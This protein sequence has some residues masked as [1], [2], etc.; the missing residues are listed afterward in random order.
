MVAN[1]SESSLAVGEEIV[2]HQPVPVRSSISASG[3]GRAR[4]AVAD[5]GLRRRVAS[6]FELRGYQ[7]TFGPINPAADEQLV[8]ILA[9]DEAY[10]IELANSLTNATARL[11]IPWIAL[12]RDSGSDAVN[13]AIE[14]GA[15]D[16]L[17][18][19]EEIDALD[20]RLAIIERRIERHPGSAT[21]PRRPERNGISQLLKSAERQAQELQ[22]L[23]RIRTAIAV[24]FA[25]PTLFRSI[26]EQVAV[27]FGY[28]HVSIYRLESGDLL[29]QH[30]VGYDDVLERIPLGRGVA[31]RVARTGEA[32]LIEDVGADPDFLAAI[33]GIRSEICVPFFH[34]GRVAG[35]FNVESTGERLLTRAD[36]RLI[37]EVTGFLGLAVERSQLMTAIQDSEQRLRL[38]LEAAGMGTWMWHPQTGEVVWSEQMGPLYGLPTGT[39][40]LSTEDWFQ[41]IHQ[42]DRGLV[43]RKD[44]QVMRFGDEYEI[45]FRV[46]LA[47]GAIR[48]LEGKGR[49]VE[50]DDAG[51][52]LSI[53]GVTMDVTGR[54]RLE[55]ERLRLVQVETERAKAKEAQRLITDTLE[56][57]SA[58]FIAVDR[59]WHPTFVNQRA[60]VMLGLNNEM[61]SGTFWEMLPWLEG[62]DVKYELQAAAESQ[63]SAI[64]DVAWPGN[65][66]WFEVHLY[67]AQDGLSISLQDV[68]ERR[69]AEE[70]QRRT[71]ER[72]RS[73]VQNAS[74]IILILD[75]H[76]TV[77]YASP[78]IER[79]I[80]QPAEEIV[81]GD[82]FSLVHPQDAKRLRRAFVKVAMTAG[83]SPP[84]VLRFRHKLG[85]YRWLEVTATNLF[86]DP[87]IEGIVANCRDVTERHDAEFNLWFLAETSSMVGTSLDLETTLNS[88]ARLIVMNLGE[89]CIVDVVNEQL[90]SEA[91]A[92]AHR[93]AAVERR[94]VQYRSAWPLNRA[95]PYGP[96]YV[97]KTGRSLLYGTI[98]DEIGQLWLS[99]SDERS[100]PVNFGFRSAIVVPLMARGVTTGVLTVASST[101]GRFSGVDLGL[102]EELARRAAM[103]VDNARLYRAARSAVEARD[104]FLSVA[105]HEL[106]T[107]ITAI[108]GFTALLDRE[109]VHRNDPDR[110]QRFVRRLTDAGARLSLLVDDMLDV[111]RIRLGQLPLRIA[112]VDLAA[113]IE[114]VKQRYEEQETSSPQRFVLDLSNRECV[115]RA[116]DDRLDQVLSNVVDNAKKYSAE[117]GDIV[118]SLVG[119]DDGCLLRV[120]DCGIGL[121]VDEL[122][123]IFRPFGR[124]ANAVSSNVSGLGIGLFISRNIIERHGGRIWA[125]SEGEGLGTTIAIWLPAGGISADD[126]PPMV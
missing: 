86:D 108:T 61:L 10:L 50:R 114:R 60:L 72:F 40:L 112:D 124:A 54:K 73:L 59:D 13:L 109:V 39:T 115:I 80:G 7:L 23:H 90:E 24:D 77:R 11:A 19:P 44:R 12:V 113:L 120:K 26:V 29:L 81:G 43:L 68:T 46:V 78:A 88:I 67:S 71:E 30:Q 84:I 27:F 3:R 31:G 64:F 16:V 92:I 100:D 4:I 58:G 20:R 111:A 45:E 48:W 70:D 121:P 104:Q 89:M 122:D 117:G 93:D 102:V 106:R 110:V 103:A 28:S 62:T 119:D 87:A 82:N 101:P 91:Y 99:G 8:T 105:A 79:V 33:S 47:N 123:S 75:R 66:R 97:L 35:V 52:V 32:V 57:M 9:G 49:V 41:L 5:P 15:S 6:V 25:L 65:E 42:E 34:K 51:N 126:L 38:A 116:D 56:R 1:Q 21:V 98:D 37:V 107:P 14:H 83:V 85:S 96:G 2:P 94:L 53:V 76:G 74:D 17:V 22:L 36:L 69:Q 63:I 118:I 95:S 18:I 55:E 125:E